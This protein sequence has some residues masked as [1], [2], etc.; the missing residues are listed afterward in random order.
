M[1]IGPPEHE[2]LA[3]T[4]REFTLEDPDPP[5]AI[6]D[7]MIDLGELLTQQLALALDPHPRKPGV[8]LDSVLAEAPAGRREAIERGGASGPFAKLAQLKK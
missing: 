1:I 4:E 6:V 2:S 3:E 5:E 8:D 7:G